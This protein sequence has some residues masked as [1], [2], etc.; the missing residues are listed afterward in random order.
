MKLQTTTTRTFHFGLAAIA[1]LAFSVALAVGNMSPA[2][3]QSDGVAGD[4]AIAPSAVQSDQN[5]NDSAQ[6]AQQDAAEQAHDAADAAQNA[7]D[8]A[9]ESRDQLESNGAPQD[10]IDAANQAIAQARADKEAADQAAQQADEASGEAKG[11]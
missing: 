2:R 1:T 10:Q 11:D 3:A 5:A 9:I 6:K 7:L 8:S 4:A